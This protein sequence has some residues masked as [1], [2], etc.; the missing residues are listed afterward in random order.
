[1]EKKKKIKFEGE[2]NFVLTLKG[3]MAAEL[4][5]GMKFHNKIDKLTDIC[6]N[7][8]KETW[9]IGYGMG[10]DGDKKGLLLAQE[11]NLFRGLAAL[12]W[13]GMIDVVEDKNVKEK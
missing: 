3:I 5:A 6:A 4:G 13:A 7:I 10:K 11:K 8:A 2:D 9:A 1:M 12:M